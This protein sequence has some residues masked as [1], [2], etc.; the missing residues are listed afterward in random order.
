MQAFRHKMTEE[1]VVDFMGVPQGRQK[2][3]K[4]YLLLHMCFSFVD[5]RVL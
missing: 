4:V 2:G 3:T 5:I 1:E